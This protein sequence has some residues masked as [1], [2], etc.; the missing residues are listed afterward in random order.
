MG[1]AQP[2]PSPGRIVQ[3]RAGGATDTDETPVL[4]VGIVTKVQDNGAK[5]TVRLMT[6]PDGTDGMPLLHGLDLGNGL[7][8]WRWPA[9]E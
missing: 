8:Q 7:N 4:V 9:R 6:N 5:V 2:K 1:T 3:V